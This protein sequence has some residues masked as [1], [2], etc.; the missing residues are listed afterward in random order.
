MKTSVRVFAENPEVEL[1]SKDVAQGRSRKLVVSS[2]CKE[3]R[4]ATQNRSDSQGS[5]G[6]P[7]KSFVVA[8]RLDRQTVQTMSPVIWMCHLMELPSVPW[9][10]RMHE[11]PRAKSIC[12]GHL[13]SAGSPSNSAAPYS[14][15]LYH[16][17]RSSK[18]QC[19]GSVRH[20]QHSRWLS[21]LVMHGEELSPRLTCTMASDNL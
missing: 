20:S 15:F 10:A 3:R 5:C 19:V 1:L 11:L 9:H 13:A 7:K 14:M 12:A 18:C 4:V 2:D 17:P 21:L 8:S 6:K 16:A